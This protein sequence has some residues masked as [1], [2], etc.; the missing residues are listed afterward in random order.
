[1]LNTEN[2]QFLTNKIEKFIKKYY[3]NKI[4]KGTIWATAIF[5]FGA[6]TLIVTEYYGYFNVFTKTAAFYVFVF[7]QLIL[8]YLLVIKFILKY[9]KLGER[10]NLENASEIIGLY[11]PSVKDKLLNTLQLKRQCHNQSDIDLIEASINQRIAAL[12]P[13]AFVNAIKL[14]NNKKHLKYILVPLI[15]ILIL[16]FIAP[17]ILKDGTN[18]I[19][20]Y[21]QFF[22]KPAPFTFKITNK[23]LRALQS[24]NFTLNVSIEGNHVPQNVYLENGANVFK[25][26]K[27][28]LNT[29]S[30]IFNN[31]QSNHKFR[32]TAAGF[33]SNEYEL[34]VQKKPAILNFEVYLDYPAYTNKQNETLKN[35]S[36]LTF[37]TGTT[38]TWKIHTENTKQLNF[39][40]D[41]K[42]KKLRPTAINYF[43]HSQLF[44]KSQV[45]SL[46]P[47][48]NT[49]LNNENISF[50]LNCV[51]DEYPT[52]SF[53]DML[54]SINPKIVYING[55]IT[56]DYGFSNLKFNYKI[57]KSEDKTRLNVLKSKP[58]NI[59]NR[60]LNESFFYT[61]DLNLANVH[62][63]EEIEYYFT[64]TDNDAVNGPKTVKS[65]LKIYKTKSNKQEEDHLAQNNK[66]FRQKLHQAANQAK[67][68]QQQAQKINQNLL[69]KVKLDFE[70]KKNAEELIEK[71]KQ[72]EKL[73]IELQNEAKKN[74]LQQKNLNA[75]NQ[76]LIDKQIQ[77]QN[78]FEN[79]LDDKT[80]KLLQN[81]QKLLNQKNKEETRES[82]QKV[83][84]DNKLLEKEFERML[85][86]YK[87]LA[88]EQKLDNTINK[89]KEIAKT[90]DMLSKQAN[91]NNIIDKQQNLQKEFADVKKDL[92]TLEQENNSQSNFKNPL[93]EQQEIEK[94]MQ[95]AQQSLQQKQEKNAAK[96][97]INAAEKMDK[98]A[99]KL[100][101]MQSEN[102]E[103]TKSVNEQHLKGL[104]KNTLKA[105]FDEEELLEVTRKTNISDSKF[106]QLGKTQK[107]IAV[108]LKTIQDSLFNLGKLV[109]QI[110]TAV[111]KETQ[112]IN[113]QLKKTLAYITERKQAETLQ[114][115]QFVLTSVN[116]LAL[117][118]SEVLQKVQNSMGEGKSRKGKPKPNMQQ[119]SKMQQ[120]LNQNMQK[121]KQQLDKE[122]GLKPGIT[123]R[124]QQNGQSSKAFSQMAQQQQMI[125]EA[126]E[127]L[128]KNGV[129]IPGGFEKT[130]QNMQ[131]TEID[132]VYK[133]ISQDALTRQKQIE[134]KL[135]EAANAERER[136]QDTKKESNTAK[137]EYMPNYNLKWLQYQKQK[138]TYVDIIKSIP[139]VLNQFYKQKLKNYYKN[140]N[141]TQN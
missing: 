30:Y 10:L 23:S 36:D 17:T 11:F 59:N 46:I 68:I 90:Q 121:A 57:I 79:V 2:F 24:N 8:L 51:P 41:C 71:Q 105:S 125:R 22:L 128:N 139:P 9:L 25:L 126:I 28:D 60:S 115:Q 48:T 85:T 99:Q 6:L 67:E 34:L 89:L 64:V 82:L 91:K 133:K 131:Q 33:Y 15:L 63:N 116:N 16:A 40:T 58:I 96:Q 20:S 86:L 31:V 141:L 38:L 80:K 3:L 26:D 100:S 5:L 18:R 53:S 69:S 39:A 97:Q 29:F 83:N 73:V 7:L 111:N 137:E 75:K 45:Y 14:N 119:I 124:Q 101:H 122:G 93:S 114:S 56:D 118:L 4:I 84:L 74:L 134:T 129:K 106:V 130:L 127:N 49:Y 32:L 19:L 120:E 50:R 54:D 43:K 35:P 21:N 70:D 65:A 37:A 12:K 61:W 77:I 107:N 66:R 42:T 78:L 94:E 52:I 47:Q 102:E 104:L 1:M 140:L 135:L 109:P 117:M 98:L 81:L 103:D 136:E 76:Q 92:K 138:S 13:I 132:L 110:T 95:E 27:K 44:T 88:F 108:N 62:P 112:N 87:R 113:Y 55:K 123:A 72:L